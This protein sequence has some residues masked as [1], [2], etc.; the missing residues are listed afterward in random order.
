[1]KTVV[2]AIGGGLSGVDSWA[3]DLRRWFEQH[4]SYRIRTLS[5]GKKNTAADFSAWHP[6]QIFGVLQALKPSIVIPNYLPLL[7]RYALTHDTPAIGMC[8]SDSDYEYY[9]PLSL[10][11]PLVGLF[12]AVS[13]E[14]HLRLATHIAHR[15]HDIVTVPYGV[16]AGPLAPVRGSDTP[17]RLLY[18]G[19]LV[20]VQKRALDLVHLVAQL[21]A[22]G[23]PFHLTVAGDGDVAPFLER[24]FAGRND[25]ALV[26]RVAM[27]DM[28]AL[29]TEHD[30]YVQ[31]SNF[32]GTSTSLLQALSAGLVPCVTLATSGVLSV[33]RDGESGLIVPVGCMDLMAQGIRQLH[34]QRDMLHRLRAGALERA[35]AF[36]AEAH[37]S[38]MAN[39]F[40]RVVSAS[41]E[42]IGEIDRAFLDRQLAS[43]QRTWMM[44]YVRSRVAELVGRK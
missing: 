25:V 35:R 32:E 5:L 17:L 19:R 41:R 42:P 24:A 44:N 31:V 16:A 6:R 10:Y 14:C 29:M 18:A 23:V 26:G 9:I 15:K 34:Q 20:Q 12:V 1:M 33:V 7:F 11:E 38:E 40:D 2:I 4:P 39:C 27:S 13:P 37:V 22:L 30:V 43:A 28:R 21:D 8:H 3:Y 36:T